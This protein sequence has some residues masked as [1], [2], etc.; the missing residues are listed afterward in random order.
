MFLDWLV[1]APVTHAKAKKPDV[2]VMPL[3]DGEVKDAGVE[4]SISSETTSMSETDDFSG[5]PVN[6]YLLFMQL[7]RLLLLYIYIC[8]FLQPKH[9]CS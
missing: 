8:Y 9:N 5:Y 1:F 3:L 6:P 4:L 2:G 7:T